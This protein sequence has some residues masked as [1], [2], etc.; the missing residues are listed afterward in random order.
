MSIS[1][2]FFI[3][4]FLGFFQ[5]IHDFPAFVKSAFGANPMRHN[6]RSAFGAFLGFFSHHRKSYAL[7]IAAGFG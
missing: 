6:L 1:H 3:F 5:S 4:I 7:A 2:L